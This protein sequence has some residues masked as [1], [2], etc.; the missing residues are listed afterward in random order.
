MR[1]RLRGGRLALLLA[2]LLAVGFSSIAAADHN[3]V[4]LIS[5][6]PIGGS[7]ASHAFFGDATGDG[8]KVFFSTQVKLVPQD[9]DDLFD[10]YQR[11]GGVTTLIS[12]GPTD[13]SDG[14]S[15]SFFTG[16]SADGSR[17]FFESDDHLVGG[18][19]DDCT[20]V[21]PDVDRV[22]RRL[23]T[24]RRHHQAHLGRRQRCL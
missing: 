7:E 21:N 18:D 15:G 14:A 5:T 12:T 2:M 17:V 23:R 20:G 8:S 13:T 16:A 9:T 24:L 3:T 22:L 4:E 11:S 1:C 6:G 10:V 19:T